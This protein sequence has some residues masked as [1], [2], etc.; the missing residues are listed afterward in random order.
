MVPLNSPR[1]VYWTI[2]SG[3]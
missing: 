1:T 3:L 2:Q